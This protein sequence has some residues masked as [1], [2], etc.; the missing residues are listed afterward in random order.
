M[1]EEQDPTAPA[2]AEVEAMEV[3]QT[4]VVVEGKGYS[5]RIQA[6]RPDLLQSMALGKLPEGFWTS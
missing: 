5:E 2:A 3:V 6:E 1:A 4:E